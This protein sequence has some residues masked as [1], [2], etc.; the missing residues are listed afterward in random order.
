ML[1]LSELKRV[2]KMEEAIYGSRRHH[3]IDDKDGPVA[4]PFE[5]FEDPETG[6][7]IYRQR[8]DPSEDYK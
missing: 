5:P 1:R 8:E 4:R 2:L 6:H 7:K 3:S